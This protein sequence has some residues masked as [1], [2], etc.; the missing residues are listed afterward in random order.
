MSHGARIAAIEKECSG[1]WGVSGITSW[2]RDRLDEWKN[3]TSL[4]P[5]QEA[6]LRT[7]EAKAFK[8]VADGG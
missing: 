3:R 8:E 2:E 7:I 1:V 4:S 6:I 5:K